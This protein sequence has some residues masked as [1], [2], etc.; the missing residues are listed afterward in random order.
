MESI[1]SKTKIETNKKEVIQIVNRIERKQIKANN[2]TWFAIKSQ[3]M[4]NVDKS[5]WIN[6]LVFIG[7]VDSKWIHI[8]F[9]ICSCQ[10]VQ[11]HIKMGQKL[12]KI[13]I[14]RHY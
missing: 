14:I 2:L 6:Y 13:T 9:F 12:T 10:L 11:K 8:Q 1:E 7:K 3:I 5:K 4:S